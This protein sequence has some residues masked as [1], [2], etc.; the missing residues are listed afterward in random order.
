MTHRWMR[1]LAPGATLTAAALLAACSSS[2]SSSTSA[3]SS[4]SQSLSQMLAAFQ[5]NSVQADALNPLDIITSTL[6]SAGVSIPNS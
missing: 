2:S 5:A 1:W 6:A 4:T 3:S